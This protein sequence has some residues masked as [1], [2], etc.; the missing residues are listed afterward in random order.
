MH[1][2]SCVF[3]LIIVDKML[4]R[5]IFIIFTLII[6]LIYPNLSLAASI[7][8]IRN[9]V[10][11][12]KIRLVLDSKS[13]VKYTWEKKN[14][15]LILKFV[16]GN[17]KIVSNVKD[18]A[19]KSV[20]LD[21]SNDGTSKLEIKLNGTYKTSIFTLSNPDRIV[22]DIFK[23][24]KNIQQVQT[25]QPV[26]ETPKN[27]ENKADNLDVAKKLPN[28][29]NYRFI[30]DKIAG[31]QFQA[32]VISIDDINRYEIRPFSA[33]G[34]YNGRGS[35]A[36]ECTRRNIIA[37]VNASYFDS[38]GWV[39]G[40]VK[41]KGKVIAVEESPR[42]ALVV[43]AGNPKIIKDLSYSSYID[44]YNGKRVV[45][46]GMNRVRVADDCVLY[47][48]AFATST[49]TNQWGRE[50]KL[51]NGRV[52]S[53][54]KLG[55]MPIEAGTVVISG[56]GINAQLLANVRPGQRLEVAGVWSDLEAAE[57]ETVVGAGPLLVEN[58]RINVRSI[59]EKF[60]LDITR[61]RSPRTAVGIKK[62]NSMFF[63]VVDGRSENSCG[64]TLQE[65]A[66]FMLK[67]GAKEALNLD[68]G[69][70]SEMVINGKIVNNP[71]DG[72]ERLISIGLGVFPK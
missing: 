71:S 8:S 64:M 63:V 49:K 65:L 18:A 34:A 40:I 10:S 62:D 15:D 1:S 60:A 61:G 13:P 16:E 50:I 4:Y 7:D 55:D 52:I 23:T 14:N 57:A 20:V 51:K 25:I 28:G 24:E 41:D 11:I 29:I 5:I 32:Y 36:D 27:K 2:E 54:S 70:S 9:S 45:V 31:K 59:E 72:K 39:I 46:K 3:L 26:K 67:L 58:G 48:D 38:D 6:N 33:A 22:I 17:K 47:N 19:I 43:K 66:D 12:D 30:K 37:A 44:L 42:S 53:V 69:G 35:L 56:H 21:T 68:G